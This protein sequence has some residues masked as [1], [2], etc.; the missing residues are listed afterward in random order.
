MA[1]ID[2]STA[3]DPHPARVVPARTPRCGGAGRDRLAQVRRSA[4]AEQGC[5]CAPGALASSRPSASSP[6]PALGRVPALFALFASFACLGVP[7]LSACPNTSAS[8]A[9]LHV[10][11][12]LT[13]P[14]V[15][16]SLNAS[17]SAPVPA[18]SACPH[19][20]AS[21]RHVGAGHGISRTARTDARAWLR[22][23]VGA[24]KGPRGTSTDPATGNTTTDRA[25]R[26][27]GNHTIPNGVRA[28]NPCEGT[29]QGIAHPTRH[30]GAGS[31]I[32]RKAEQPSDDAPVGHQTRNVKPGK[33]GKM[34][35]SD[36]NGSFPGTYAE[37]RDGNSRASSFCLF[38]T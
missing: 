14:G 38:S 31:N 24:K 36:V 2:K 23:D 3:S 27:I 37:D 11:A 35:S 22:D 32:S 33:V 13:R 18:S 15:P 20:P 30:V 28:N 7:A 25:G 4:E 19:A 6:V 12:S 17:A 8:L 26:D 9:S 16:A 34:R 10:S 21:S 1:A 5:D 29:S